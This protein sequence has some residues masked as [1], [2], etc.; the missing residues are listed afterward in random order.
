MV[1]WL[2]KF[3]EAGGCFSLELLRRQHRSLVG[4]FFEKHLVALASNV[5]GA[6]ASVLVVAEVCCWEVRP[7]AVEES[8]SGTWVSCLFIS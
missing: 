1:S 4:A 5:S 2:E 6:E 3:T 8:G 7:E